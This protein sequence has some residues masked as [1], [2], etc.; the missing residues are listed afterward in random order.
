ML[1]PF[2]QLLKAILSA[3]FRVEGG[4]AGKHQ[5][6]SPLRSCCWTVMAVILFCSVCLLHQSLPSGS[7]SISALQSR[8]PTFSLFSVCVCVCLYIDID[9]DR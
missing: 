9:T 2:V 8:R 7:H 4:V 5:C 6:L 3:I 1:W